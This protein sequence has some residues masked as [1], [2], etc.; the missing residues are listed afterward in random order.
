MNSATIAKKDRTRNT[1]KKAYS[2]WKTED[3]AQKIL[4][5]K[6]ISLSSHQKHRSDLVKDGGLISVPYEGKG[7]G[8]T[9]FFPAD[10]ILIPPNTQGVDLTKE[11][12]TLPVSKGTL[13]SMVIDQAKNIVETIEKDDAWKNVRTIK[14]ICNNIRPLVHN[15]AYLESIGFDLTLPWHYF[16]KEKPP[17]WKGLFGWKDL[18][19]TLGIPIKASGPEFENYQVKPG[20]NSL[21]VVNE[22]QEIKEK[23]D[24]LSISPKDTDGLLWVYIF[25]S[26]PEWKRYF[27]KVIEELDSASRDSNH[28]IKK[29]QDKTKGI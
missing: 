9:R 17:S 5:K 15:L 25:P 4:D 16:E 29:K 3:E 26:L 1:V 11:E 12:G 24:V 20:L 7:K 28:K 13:I 23:N 27:L 6:G 2:G 8:L 21:F 18:R 22:F 14:K 19:G 10:E